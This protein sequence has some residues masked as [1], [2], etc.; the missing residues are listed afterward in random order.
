M[1]LDEL[2]AENRD[3]LVRAQ[4]LLPDLAVP[5]TAKRSLWLLLWRAVHPIFAAAK[6]TQPGT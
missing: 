2:T 1:H 3:T 6:R 5:T 4:R